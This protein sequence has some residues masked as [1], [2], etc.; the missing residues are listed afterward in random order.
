MKLLKQATRYARFSLIGAFAF[1]VCAC[2]HPEPDQDAEEIG[3]VAALPDFASIKDVKQR[4][5]RFFEFMQ[6]LIEAENTK[7]REQR[8]QILRLHNAFKDGRDLSAHDREWLQELCKEY[9]VPSADLRPEETFARLL[10]HVDVVPLELALV[11][12]ANESAWGRSRFARRWNNIFGER[13]LEEGCG[14]VPDRRPPGA[15]Y[16]VAIFDSPTHSVRSY[17]DNLNSHPAYH[18]FRVLRYEKRLAGERPDGYTLILGL[19]K[20][21]DTGM[22]YVRGLRTMM[23]QNKDLIVIPE[24]QPAL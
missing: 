22:D 3:Q 19:R 16:K 13:C 4:K 2:G 10:M 12:A 7:V 1:S 14:I 24:S 8:L 5:R 18:R 21:S 20:Y 17:I 11:Q 23:R 6:P 9:Q 15:T